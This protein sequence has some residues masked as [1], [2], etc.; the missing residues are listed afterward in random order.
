MIGFKPYGIEK[1]KKE[2]VN[3]TFDEFQGFKY[4]NYDF[5]RQDEAAAKM[6]ISR[7][8]FTR[9]YNSALKKIALAF[10]EGH[11]IVIV[12]GDVQFEQEW[13]RC[14]KCFKLIDRNTGHVR[15]TN[16]KLYGNEELVNIIKPTA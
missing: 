3:L 4:I 14:L 8:T 9:L 15:C 2:S 11:S 13:Q 1:C 5:I 12:G 6:G 16:C 7:P 10:V